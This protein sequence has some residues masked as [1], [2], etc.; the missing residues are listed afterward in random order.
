VTTFC[1]G[2]GQ[3]LNLCPSLGEAAMLMSKVMRFRRTPGKFFLLE[4]LTS[5]KVCQSIHFFLDASI[6]SVLML[7]L[8][9][10][11]ALMAW[12]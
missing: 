7:A 12:G 11:Y 4:K 5:F 6:L 2:H 3:L 10:H 1:I 8:L 9:Y